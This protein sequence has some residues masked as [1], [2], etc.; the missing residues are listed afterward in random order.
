MWIFVKIFGCENTVK[1]ASQEA[2]VPVGG[3]GEIA[4]KQNANREVGVAAGVP[5]RRIIL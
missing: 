3:P 1:N 5:R 2:G 4:R